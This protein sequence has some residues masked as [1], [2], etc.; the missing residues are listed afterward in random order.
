[1]L[2]FPNDLKQV[3]PAFSKDFQYNTDIS[4]VMN[5]DNNMLEI[6]FQGTVKAVK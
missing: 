3:D 4:L 2:L 6:P 1:M 5:R